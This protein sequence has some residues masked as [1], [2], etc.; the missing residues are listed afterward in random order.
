MIYK[1]NCGNIE[2]I[3]GHGILFNAK[4][5]IDA[6]NQRPFTNREGIDFY[7]DSMVLVIVCFGKRFRGGPERR[8]RNKSLPVFLIPIFIAKDFFNAGIQLNKPEIY[9]RKI[10]VINKRAEGLTWKID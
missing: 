2:K 5:G 6:C 7:F 9:L 8:K 1:G 10:P 4:T 3:N